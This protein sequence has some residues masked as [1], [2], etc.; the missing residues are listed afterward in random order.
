MKNEIRTYYIWKITTGQGD[1][2]TTGSLLDYVYFEN[3]YKTIAIDLKKK[4]QALE[5]E[6]K[7][8][9]MMD[10][11]LQWMFLKVAFSKEKIMELLAK[12]WLL[13]LMSNGIL[14]H[15]LWSEDLSK[16]FSQLTTVNTYLMSILI[17][18][19]YFF[20]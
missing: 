4:Q 17:F 13:K 14:R 9:M 8:T 11:R 18:S 2:Y 15:Y 3:Y 19:Q 7:A 10:W 12:K 1:D 5:P 6:L 20:Q 16:S